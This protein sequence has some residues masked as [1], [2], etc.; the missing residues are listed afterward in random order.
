[1]LRPRHSLSL[2]T[3]LLLLASAPLCAQKEGPQQSKDDAAA[4]PA[5]NERSLFE[6]IFGKNNS[7]ALPLPVPFSIDGHPAG[8]TQG[9]VSF[10]AE[11]SRFFAAPILKALENYL[12]EEIVAP[13]HANVD[14]DGFILLDQLQTENIT[15][16]YD[17]STLGIIIITKPEARRT[18]THTFGPGAPTPQEIAQAIRPQP[19]SGHIN[20][21]VTDTHTQ[22]AFDDD[23]TGREPN[24][25]FRLERF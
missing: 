25:D 21:F 11:N 8:E 7:T 19:V 6:H 2:V 20:F 18:L 24:P 22:K 16:T 17:P 5:L 23:P 4:Q 3:S 10:E 14:K 15:T 13:L 12:L 9:L 1:M